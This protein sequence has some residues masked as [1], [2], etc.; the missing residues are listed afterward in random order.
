MESRWV[1]SAHA[2]LCGH[3]ELLVGMACESARRDLAPIPA[4]PV[5][6]CGGGDL[7]LVE[8]KTPSSQTRAP[9][10]VGSTP[11]VFEAIVHTWDPHPARFPERLPVRL[12][13]DTSTTAPQSEAVVEGLVEYEPG[14]GAAPLRFT[15]SP[16]QGA[17]LVVGGPVMV[18]VE[19]ALGGAAVAGIITAITPG[20][21]AT[22]VTVAGLARSWKQVTEVLRA[23]CWRDWRSSWADHPLGSREPVRFEQHDGQWGVVAGELGSVLE[24][25]EAL[26]HLADYLLS[27]CAWGEQPALWWNYAFFCDAV[28]A[29][30]HLLPAT[31]S[32]QLSRHAVDALAVLFTREIFTPGVFD[33]AGLF[34]PWPGTPH[35]HAE[36]LCEAASAFTEAG[37]RAPKP[38]EVCVLVANPVGAQLIHPLNDGED[39]RS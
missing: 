37:A 24:C 21:D 26:A 19:R 20:D 23:A 39:R 17:G 33:D 25:P 29:T 8:L 38:V 12:H 7:V 32:A 28:T 22:S 36:L 27:A 18:E 30:R 14:A 34:Q 15:V 4:R 13:T 16:A 10:L 3:R 31:D 35:T 2:P 6:I 9:L 11:S 5:H 1:L